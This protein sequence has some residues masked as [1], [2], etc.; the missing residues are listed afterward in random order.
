MR[1][2][3]VAPLLG[4]SLLGGCAQP[5]Y[6]FSE[7]AGSAPSAATS[8]ARAGRVFLH[9]D[10]GFSIL[11]QGQ[12]LAA[13]REWNSARNGPVRI[14]VATSGSAEAG[15]W[16]IRQ[17]DGKV[18]DGASDE[19]RPQPVAV[20]ERDS[21]GGGSIVLYTNRLGHRDLRTVVAQ[22]LGVALGGGS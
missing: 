5:Q 2:L 21:A 19:W 6:M 7:Q 1:S 22:E 3:I 17:P 10:N 13:A 9:V 20:I 16:T 12:I 11:E 14:D 4:L 8:S 15:A 18:L